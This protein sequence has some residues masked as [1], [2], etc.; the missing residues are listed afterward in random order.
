MQFAAHF[1]EIIDL[2]AL[3]AR[4]LALEG[5][6]GEGVSFFLRWTWMGSWLKGLQAAQIPLPRLLSLAHDGAD[7]ALALIGEGLAHRKL[8]SVPAL[9]LNES[10]H[11]DG[12]RPFIEYNG[13]LCRREDS[14]HVAHGFCGAMD[15]RKDWRALHVSGV[16]F[17]SPLPDVAHV[18]RTVLRD[19]A[20]VYFVD[21]GRVRAAGGDYLSLLSA[22][23]RGQIRRSL[24]EGP[25]E[26]SVEAADDAATIEAW[27]AD[28]QRLNTGRHSDNAW[29]NAFFRDFARRI[30]LA[31]LADGSVELL[32]IVSGGETLGYLMTFLWAGR[33]MNYQSAFA[34]PHTTRSKPGLMCHAAAVG[35][36][37]QAGMEEYS[38]LAG[39]DRYKQSLS[40]GAH[41]MEWWVLER[42]DWRLEAEAALRKIFRR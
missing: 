6:A 38:L 17:A 2:A 29:E 23:T 42:F 19:A 5:Q 28:M 10:G 32:R 21:L 37:A 3:E 20:P 18:R 26:P 14:L 39:R 24:K 9:L 25:G 34:E 33:A 11:R 4:W 30:A 15:A 40:T 12:D 7:I 31:G 22:N 13:L 8:G 35:R 27:L 16:A 36:Y 41:A 1:E